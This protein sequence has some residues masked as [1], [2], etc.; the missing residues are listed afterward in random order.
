MKIEQV[1]ADVDELKPNQY[2]DKIIIKWLA[3]LD[4]KIY[5]EII[6]THEGANASLMREYDENDMDED[7]LVPYPYDDIYRNYVFAMIDFTN[8]ESDRYQNSMAMF[9]TSYEKYKKWYHT[10]HM[11]ISAEMKL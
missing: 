6:S 11:P 9:N 2:D 8:G 7:L 3:E 5:T 10:T 1:L 4:G